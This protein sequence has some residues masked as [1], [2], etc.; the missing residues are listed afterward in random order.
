MGSALGIDILLFSNEL[1]LWTSLI[2]KGK[3]S[4]VG[5]GNL[6]EFFDEFQVPHLVED[7][8]QEDERFARIVITEKG[9][10]KAGDRVCDGVVVRASW[11]YRL[12]KW[13]GLVRFRGSIVEGEVL[14]NNR[15]A[16]LERLEWVCSEDPALIY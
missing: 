10:C 12:G 5:Y 6:L 11:S 4:A 8:V 2:H 14:V 16:T 9:R 13:A 7:N 3:V 1:E 15:R